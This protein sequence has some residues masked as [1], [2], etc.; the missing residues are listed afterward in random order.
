MKSRTVFAASVAITTLALTLATPSRA[1]SAMDACIDAF[2]SEHVPK[3]R[4]VK[5]RKYRSTGSFAA[6]RTGRILLSAKG[7]KSGTM[8]A[9]ASCSVDGST[10]SLDSGT[11]ATKV[12]AR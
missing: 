6:A 3:D 5:V 12:A 1:D 8:I 2:V 9:S 11:E 4:T 7:A 10:V